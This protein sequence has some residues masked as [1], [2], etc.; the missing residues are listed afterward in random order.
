MITF[1]LSAYFS[2]YVA[3]VCVV[4]SIISQI[5]RIDKRHHNIINFLTTLKLFVSGALISI[6][7]AP[8]FVTRALFIENYVFAIALNIYL[9]ALEDE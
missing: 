8:V 4:I 1:I 6:I 2:L 7:Y 5:Y 9:M 3:S